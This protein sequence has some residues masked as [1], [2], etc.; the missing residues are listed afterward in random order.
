MRLNTV[1]F[2]FA[3]SAVVAVSSAASPSLCETAITRLVTYL[4]L[5]STT[6]QALVSVM[7]VG[8]NN[9]ASTCV[10]HILQTDDCITAFTEFN[11]SL[12]TLA[13]ALPL[14]TAK[15]SN[16]VFT[17]AF[18]SAKQK[19][20]AL[21]TKCVTLKTDECKDVLDKINKL[22]I[23]VFADRTSSLQEKLKQLQQAQT[24]SVTF[25]DCKKAA[26][27]ENHCLDASTQFIHT[28]NDLLAVDTEDQLLQGLLESLDSLDD[29][30]YVCDE[31]APNQ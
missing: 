3:L 1:A 20:A 27:A 24:W 19:L 28:M 7:F 6:A 5:K 10:D 17:Y 18:D 16:E 13:E 26:K 4:R 11:T 2:I 22:L 23:E 15:S 29:L 12:A 21:L 31:I 9:L 8:R 14:R 25:S 30:R